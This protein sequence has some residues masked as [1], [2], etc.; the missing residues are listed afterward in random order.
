MRTFILAALMTIAVAAPARATTIYA[1]SGPDFLTFV[2]TYS[3]PSVCRVTG[4]FTLPATLPANFATSILAPLDYSFT[5][6]VHV[7]DPTTV[8]LASFL[9]GTDAFGR[10]VQW[11]IQLQ[12]NTAAAPPMRALGTSWA[13]LERDISNQTGI[14]GVQPGGSAACFNCAPGTWTISTVNPPATVPEPSTWLLVVTGLLAIGRITQRRF[15][16][17]P[18][19]GH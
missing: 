12:T 11:D 17:T 5:D 18:T 15:R 4:F 19:L 3:C 16:A 10:P 7:F 6:G 2:G 1:Y 9:M 13:V 8:Q 14:L